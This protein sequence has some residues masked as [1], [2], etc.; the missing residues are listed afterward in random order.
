LPDRA[1]LLPCGVALL[2][3]A[4]LLVLALQMRVR[5]LP[6]P[7][8]LAGFPLV[9]EAA[10]AVQTLAASSSAATSIISAPPAA[11]AP[12]SFNLAPAAP[13]RAKIRAARRETVVAPL[14]APAAATSGQA[15]A[16]AATPDTSATDMMPGLES[17]IDAAV[18]EA[19]IMPD[20]ARRQHRQGRAQVKFTYVDGKVD[21]V[22]LVA[23]SESRL[24]DNAAM[25]A[26]RAA[27]YPVPPMALHG[28]RLNLMLWIEFR[29]QA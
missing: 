14:P 7:P 4:A 1:W 11:P 2:A 16:R 6:A 22:Q 23:T 25:Q 9:L 28:R 29:L 17:R 27:L 24:L 20:A 21:G 19:A 13:T 12:L 26:V 8:D 10:A 18:R 15:V 5:T 3:H